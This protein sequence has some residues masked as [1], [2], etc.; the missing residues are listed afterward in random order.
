[1]VRACLGLAAVAAFALPAPASADT[2]GYCDPAATQF[3]PVDVP[4]QG[5]A[6]VPV[7]GVQER[8]IDLNGVRT[9]LLEA[10]DPE[11]ET[12]VVFLSPG[13]AAD[14]ATLLPLVTSANVR[15][16][17]FD[18]PGFGHA[19]PTWG[20]SQRLDAAASYLE[21][22]LIQLGVREVHLVVHDIGGP[23]GM[24][25]GARHPKQLRSVTLIDTGLLLGYRH[26]QLAQIS[27]QPD[28]GEAFW[29]QMNRAEWNFGVQQ[30]QTPQRPLPL[31]FANRLYDDFDRETR[32]AT[33]GVYR[34]TDE[35]E[36]NAFAQRQASILAQQPNRPALVIWGAGDPYL[37][38]EMANRQREGFPSA[39][40][41]IFGDSGH[42]PFADNPDRTRELVVPFILNAIAGDASVGA[43]QPATAKRKHPHKRKK[44]R[45]RRRRR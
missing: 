13:G 25:W 11:A 24:E 8:T 32:C 20:A 1:M 5:S 9:R 19:E 21:G 45:K 44:K 39:R 15:A 22:A 26:H 4:K 14:W 33:I 42:W 37:P 2:L 36:I 3:D 40:V 29:L 41:E 34:S 27:R 35:P 6:S 17:A 30:G 43:Q 23:P 28:V 7:P 16:I 18:L 12:A 10:G 38:A 31:D